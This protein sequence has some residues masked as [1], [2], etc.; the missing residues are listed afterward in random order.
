MMSDSDRSRGFEGRLNNSKTVG[1]PILDSTSYKKSHWDVKLTKMS[2]R[3]LFE[4]QNT[5]TPLK[6]FLIIIKLTFPQVISYSTIPSL[7]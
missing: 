1:I 2:L 7:S 5:N 6:R 4:V 3:R